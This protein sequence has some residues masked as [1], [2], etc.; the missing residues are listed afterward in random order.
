[1][2]FFTGGINE[3]GSDFIEEF[4]GFNSS[5]NG[6]YFASEPINNDG[7][8]LSEIKGKTRRE[9]R[10]YTRMVKKFRG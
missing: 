6:R 9:R 2:A 4:K 5:P 8:P 3:D 10:E 1:M 7:I